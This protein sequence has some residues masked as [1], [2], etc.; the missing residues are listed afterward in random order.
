[1][2]ALSAACSRAGATFRAV[3]RNALPVGALIAELLADVVGTRRRSV[4]CDCGVARPAFDSLGF[5][6]LDDAAA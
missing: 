1:M 3:E 5:T 4:D 6:P 2:T